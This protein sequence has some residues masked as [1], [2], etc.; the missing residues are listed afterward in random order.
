MTFEEEHAAFIRYHLDNRT[1]NVGDDW[2]GDIG[3]VN[4]YFCATS[5]GRSGEASK[6]FIRNM[7]CSIG[8]ADLTLPILPGCRDS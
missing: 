3:T 5:G 8:G 4:H 7:K 6:I 1:G 2:I